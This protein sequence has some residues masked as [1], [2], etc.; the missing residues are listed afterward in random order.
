MA[1]ALGCLFP[2]SSDLSCSVCKGSWRE[3]SLRRRGALGSEG[4]GENDMYESSIV[5]TMA[6]ALGCLSPSRG[7]LS[8][9]VCEG[10]LREESLRRRGA[11][12]REGQGENSM[13][14]SLLV[15]TMATA[16]G[17]LSPSRGDLSCSVCK[18]SWREESL[19]RRGALGREGQGEND[20]YESSIVVT[21]ATALGCRS[22]FRGDLSCSVCEGSWREESLRR[23]GALGSEGQGENSMYVSASL[24]TMALLVT[25]YGNSTGLSVSFLK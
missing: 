17:C 16:L 7:D 19:R 3:E 9:S 5:V 13:Y 2:S 18:G 1:T 22:S 24:V 21:M 25:I 10:S 20:T 14:V 6:T 12:G 8:C 23:R 4:Q 15:V 11:L